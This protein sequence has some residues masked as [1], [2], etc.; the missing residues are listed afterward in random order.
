VSR[1]LR[2]QCHGAKPIVTNYLVLVLKGCLGPQS[3]QTRQPLAVVITVV[4]ANNPMIVASTTANALFFFWLILS[5]FAPFPCEH[6]I[7]EVEEIHTTLLNRKDVAAMAV[8]AG[9]CR[10]TWKKLTLAVGQKVNMGEKF[11]VSIVSHPRKN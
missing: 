7:P 11:T 1:V 10:I 9:K 5:I 4:A 2:L 6:M 3:R 8:P